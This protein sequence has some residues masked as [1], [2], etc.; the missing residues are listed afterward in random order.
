MGAH[1]HD[2]TRVPRSLS[3]PGRQARTEQEIGSTERCGRR[4]ALDWRET[5]VSVDGV[6]TSFQVTDIAEGFWA[7]VGRGPGVDITLNGEGVALEEIALV[8]L[9]RDA[10]GMA[11]TRPSGRGA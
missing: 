5:V 8:R 4:D 1:G 10:L 9:R 7:A 11:P 6:P 2:L 3:D